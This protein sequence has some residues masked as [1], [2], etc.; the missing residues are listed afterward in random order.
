LKRTL[1][2]C[3]SEAGQ[4]E[5]AAR[6]LTPELPTYRNSYLFEGNALSMDRLKRLVESIGS[7]RLVID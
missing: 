7:T 6:Y 4:P 3:T 1:A 2:E 5:N